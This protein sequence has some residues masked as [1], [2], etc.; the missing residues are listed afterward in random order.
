MNIFSFN[1]GPARRYENDAMILWK[2]LEYKY[3]KILGLLRIIDLSSNRLS[4]KIPMKLVSLRELVEVNLSRNHLSGTI[5]KKINQ[6]KRL[7]SLDLSHNQLYGNIPKE[8]DNLSSLAYLDLSDNH[9]WGKIPT[10]TQ[11]QS[12]DAD[13]YAG[14]GLY[15]PPLT[16]TCSEAERLPISSNSSGGSEEYWFDMSCFYVGM[17]VGYTV[18]FWA[19]CGTLVF[20]PAARHAYFRSLNNFGDW[21]Y[22]KMAKLRRGVAEINV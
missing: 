20:K 7:E 8:F 9:L 10:S 5:P 1:G 17:S 12:F 3:E 16:N 19:V 15:G 4:G 18:G 22:V 13:L 14:N 21:F 6:L 11:L 2:G